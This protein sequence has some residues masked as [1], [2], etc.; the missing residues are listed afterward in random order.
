MPTSGLTL[1]DVIDSMRKHKSLII[2]VTIVSAVAGAIFY[3][4]GPKRF[5]AKTEFVVRNP[6]YSDRNNLYNYET[7]FIDY[8][9]NEDDV[10]RIILMAN[11]DMVQSQVIKNL[12]LGK[13]YSIDATSRK[14]EQELG[15]RFYKNFN[16]TRTEY[17]D[18]ILSYTDTDPERAAKVAN[19]SVHVLE[20]AYGDFYRDMRRGMFRSIQDKIRDEDSSINALTDSLITM[21]EQY[22]IYDIISPSRFN[23]MLGT[24]KESG[25]K[26]FA[27]G[28]ETIQNYES[29]KDQLV[30]DR[31]KQ[32]TIIN[33]FETGIRAD[34]LPMIKVVTVAKAPVSPKG[35]GGMYTVLACAFLGLFFSTMLMSF[36]DFYLA[37]PARR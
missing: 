8:F 34:Q 20:L 25:Q 14:G 37:K 30:S 28:V 32:T 2:V 19:E 27:R 3:V 1:V 22:H 24:M 9:A 10:D 16:I 13:A 6:L 31:A 23:L 21:R 12:D 7:K 5:E 4:A 36:A 26:G 15:R 29:L 17:K 35:I 11:S 33:Q 18:L